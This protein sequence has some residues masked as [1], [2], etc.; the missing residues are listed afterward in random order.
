MMPRTS[1]RTDLRPGAIAVSLSGCLA[2]GSIAAGQGLSNRIEQVQRN[3]QRQE[4]RNSD[5]ANMLS[6]LLYT[7]ISVQFD[8]TPARDAIEYL[9]TV[10]GI[11]IVGRYLDDRAGHGLDPEA[12]INLDAE[13]QPALT[14][15]ERVL[16]QASEYD[17]TS[18]QLREGFV[19]VGTKDRLAS[20]ASR[21]IRYYPIRDLLFEIPRFDNAP[22]FDLNQA[23][24]QGGQGGGGGGGRGGGGG[25]GAGGGGGG[26]G[27]IFGQPGQEEDQM[28]EEERAQQII[29]LIVETVE[30]NAWQT[31]GGD[32]ATI[33]YYH[34]QLIIRAPDFVHRQIGGYPYALT[35]RSSAQADSERRYV[36]FSGGMSNIRVVDIR[37]PQDVGEK[38]GDD[39]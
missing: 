19:E 13:N 14:V 36:T 22:E 1:H 23:I 2:F 35:A 39:E 29:D 21:Q 28:S 12:G 31:M 33:R 5:K 7:D 38:A 9:Q 34:G 16:E 37:R 4:A 25:G 11:N 3:Q 17:E 30:P 15:L 32:W 26:G 27:G 10:L 20:P 24:D 8:D 6:V 18:W